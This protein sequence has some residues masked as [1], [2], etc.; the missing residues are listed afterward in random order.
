MNEKLT[1]EEIKQ[2]YNGEWVEL[3]EVEWDDCEQDPRAGVVRVH[4]KD[5]KEFKTLV[6]QNRPKSS[7]LLYVGDITFPEGIVFS[8]NL[9]QYVG[10][11]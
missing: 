6:M 3:T 8:A 11:K 1:W 4:A 9:H 10:I 2:R 7:A 5:K